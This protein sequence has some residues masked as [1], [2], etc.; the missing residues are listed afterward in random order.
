M[1]YALARVGL[2]T[3]DA[4]VSGFFILDLSNNRTVDVNFLSSNTYPEFRTYWTFSR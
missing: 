3:Y 1:F 2:G 4:Y